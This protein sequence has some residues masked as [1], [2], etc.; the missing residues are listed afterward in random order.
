MVS[1]GLFAIVMTLVAGAYLMIINVSRQA[2][3]ISTAV[4]GVSY[5][6]EDM[7]RTIRTGSG[8]GCGL[9]AGIDCPYAALGTGG[10]TTFTL[11]D[12]NNLAQTFTLKTV[13]GNGVI[14]QNSTALTDPSINVTSLKFY[15]TGT[16]PASQGDYAPPYV[17]ILISGT[18]T[19]GKQVLPF[20]VETS[21][22]MR[23]VDL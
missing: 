4:D 7:A 8:Y 22:T 17:T 5:A 18:V 15:A 12:Q 11:T 2:E 13:N 6:L 19:A 14:Y 21:A 23:G 20:S 1:I 16:K 3:G 10:S 9:I